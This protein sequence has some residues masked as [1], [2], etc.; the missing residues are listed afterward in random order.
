LSTRHVTAT[1]IPSAASSLAALR[2]EIVG[3]G[4]Y[5]SCMFGDPRTAWGW[6]DDAR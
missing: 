5:G 3:S 4:G 2:G 1:G 6:R